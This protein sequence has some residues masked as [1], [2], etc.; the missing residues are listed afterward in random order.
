MVSM[1]KTLFDG[2]S[3]LSIVTGIFVCLQMS[4]GRQIQQQ[5][6]ISSLLSPPQHH[7]RVLEILLI[8]PNVLS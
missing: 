7:L 6:T 4:D 5:D 3:R 2:I 1:D 8:L